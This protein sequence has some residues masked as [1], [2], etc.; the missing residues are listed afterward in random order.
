MYRVVNLLITPL[1]PEL[2]CGATAS[3]NKLMLLL[4]QIDID[5]RRLFVPAS[6]P[7]PTHRSPNS[8]GENQAGTHSPP[9]QSHSSLLL[10][11]SEEQMLETR[12][13]GAKGHD[14]N[15]PSGKHKGGCARPTGNMLDRGRQPAATR[16]S[17]ACYHTNQGH[18]QKSLPLTTHN[19]GFQRLHDTAARRFR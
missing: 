12:K 17:V 4:P 6:T 19:T 5:E 10:S 9:S 13:T 7:C 15:Q 3:E 18:D 16:A 8:W 14:T 1:L 2:G 11:G